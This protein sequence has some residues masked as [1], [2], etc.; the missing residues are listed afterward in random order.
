[1]SPGCPRRLRGLDSE[2]SASPPSSLINPC[3]SLLGKNPGA[4]VF[5]VIFFGPSSIARFRARCC[6]CVSTASSIRVE[7]IHA[8]LL[9]TQNT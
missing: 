8:Q 3:A 9:S 2:S 4:T 6:G 7:A 1:M 5:V